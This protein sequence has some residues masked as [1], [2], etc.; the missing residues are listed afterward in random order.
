MLL[1][2]LNLQKKLDFKD[3]RS[4]ILVILEHRDLL[5][6]LC[7]LVRKL[8]NAELKPV[9]MTNVSLKEWITSAASVDSE[10]CNTSITYLK[11][12]CGMSCI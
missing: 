3:L 11:Q 9:F 4:T 2:S 7:T 8:E 12:N 5:V 1:L 6:N 10:E